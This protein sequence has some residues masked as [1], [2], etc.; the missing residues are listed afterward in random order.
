MSS[1]LLTAPHSSLCSGR[2]WGQL[3]FDIVFGVLLPIGCLI[4]DPIVFRAGLGD[5]L[6]GRYALFAYMVVG[7]AIFALIFWL[8]WRG[9]P[10]FLAG[11]FLADAIFALMLGVVL[12]PFSAMGLAI[13]IGVLGFSPFLT[14]VVFYGHS[15]RAWALDRPTTWAGLVLA[16]F[17]FTA[18]FAGPPNSTRRYGLGSHSRLGTCRIP[19]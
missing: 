1:E 8:L 2:T 13:G 5:P 12:L 16:A 14:F 10:A 9:L 4:A 11:F 3:V 6:F 19:R 17:G 15:L 18:A 7:S